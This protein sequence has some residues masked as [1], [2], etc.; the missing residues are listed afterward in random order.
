MREKSENQTFVGAF[1]CILE[2][3]FKDFFMANMYAIK[4]AQSH[5]GFSGG[6]KI[7]YGMKN[8]QQ[9]GIISHK[10]SVIITYK[11]QL[12]LKIHTTAI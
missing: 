10:F 5:N 7:G 11:K 1:S 2:E 4:S 6:F 12:K 8:G 3:F 9:I